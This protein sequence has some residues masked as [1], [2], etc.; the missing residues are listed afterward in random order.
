MR[1]DVARPRVFLQRAFEA[2]A[3]ERSRERV[4]IALRAG[5]RR[6]GLEERLELLRLEHHVL[7]VC[8]RLRALIGVLVHGIPERFHHLGE[9]PGFP[10]EGAVRIFVV[11]DRVV[12]RENMDSWHV[13]ETASYPTRVSRTVDQPAHEHERIHTQ[14]PK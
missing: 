6:L 7:H 9:A 11:Q 2:L 10:A 12:R 14:L 4:R 8:G 5:A 1:H 3:E 13:N